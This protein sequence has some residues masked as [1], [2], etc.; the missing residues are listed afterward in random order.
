M[1]QSR[2]RRCHET[3][4]QNARFSKKE[5]TTVETFLHGRRFAAGL[6]LLAFMA[7]GIP[8][9]IVNGAGAVHSGPA[10]PALFPQADGLEVEW[11]EIVG[12][13]QPG[14]KV[15]SGT[16]QVAGGGQPWT[17]ASG[18]AELDLATGRLQFQVQGFVLAGGNAIG[19]PDN[20]T[21]V[22]GTLVCDTTGTAN[23]NS[24][25]VDTPLVPLS[26]K[27]DARFR[28]D[29]GPLPLACVNEP[30]LAFLVRTAGGAW[31]ANGAVRVFGGRD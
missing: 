28:G 5:K 18:S 9:K 30:N 27:G 4:S 21:M 3:K 12:I 10:K 6:V 2:R 14:N 31:I 8:I 26:A 24:T 7:I 17:T 19:T 23:G 22:K 13:I 1:K 29:L 11:K 15:G 20:V 16:G 25:L